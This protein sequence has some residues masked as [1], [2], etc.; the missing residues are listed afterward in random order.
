MATNIDKALY[1]Q[2]TGIAAAAEAEEPIEIEIVDPESVTIDMGDLEI[3]IQ[4]GE[5]SIDDFDAN[6][7]EYLDDGVM[8]TLASDLI[9][10][11]DADRNSRKDWADTFVKGLEVLGFKY[12]D[13][14]DPWQDMRLS[15][16][17][18]FA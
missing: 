10:L 12:E 5:P 2:P 14:T 1:Q 11:I 18:I 16:A 9:G 6:L 4:K 3:S 8:S 13:R 17:S 7:A 15:T